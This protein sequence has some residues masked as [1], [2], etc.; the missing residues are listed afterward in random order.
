MRL[1][2]LPLLL[3]AA[4]AFLLPAPVRSEEGAALS[5]G[6]E[7]TE[8]SEHG[9]AAIV[10][11]LA[12]LAGNQE[13]S[14]AFKANV[15]YKLNEGYVIQHDGVPHV[16][17]TALAGMAFLAAG[18]VPGR[19]KYGAQVEGA[20]RYILSCVSD[21]GMIADHDSRMY[22]HAFATLF[23][24]EVYGMT[25]DSTVKTAL[26]KATEFTWKCQN[27]TGGWRYVPYAP[28]SDMSITVCQMMALRSARNIG[29]RIPKETIERAVNYVLMSAHTD[30]FDF[31]GSFDYQ[32]RSENP[33]QTRTSFALTAAGLAT[34]YSAG[35]YTDADI[36]E[37]IRKHRIDR[38][39]RG[40]DAPPR[41]ETILRHVRNTYRTT[42][43][44][45]YF[46]YYGNYYAVQAMFVAGGKDWEE[47]FSRVQADLVDMQ[48]DDGH[49]PIDVPVGDAYATASA[50][51]ILSI[52]YRYLPIF[53]R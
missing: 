40:D 31:P 28:D 53:Q 21:D 15:G 45:H 29:I 1:V 16:G 48:E 19:G 44:R 5:G 30:P 38:F 9:R 13:P 8:L 17:V 46:F 34:L 18:H 33:I 20:I 2:L 47:Y 36:L 42:P 39:L 22:S 37:H 14:G 10:R 49:W 26:E 35:L 32:W 24:S 25:R 23:L 51:L 27:R 12:W 6:P 3:L 11:G 52:P 7:V 50:C 4:G 43:T 41:I